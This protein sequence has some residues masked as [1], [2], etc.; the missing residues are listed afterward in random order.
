MRQVGRG[1][2]RTSFYRRCRIEWDGFGTLKSVSVACFRFIAFKW[3]SNGTINCG[4]RGVY[5]ID[6]TSLIDACWIGK[7]YGF[8]V[9]EAAPDVLSGKIRSQNAAWMHSTQL[10]ALFGRY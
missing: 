2:Y 3:R 4:D 9:F 5:E 10:D 1:A 6:K 7:S 8:A